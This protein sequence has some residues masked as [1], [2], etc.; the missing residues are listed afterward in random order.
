MKDLSFQLAPFLE[1]AGTHVADQL[2]SPRTL[3]LHTSFSLTPYHKQAKYIYVARE[4]KDTAVSNFYFARNGVGGPEYRS[5]TFDEFFDKYID[6]QVIYGDY[7]DHLMGWWEH[8][9]DDNVLFL[10]YE[11]MKKDPHASVLQVARFISNDSVDYEKL[12]TENNCLVLN[13]IVENTSFQCMKR[14]IEVVVQTATN[15]SSGDSRMDKGVAVT[16]FFRK[17]IVGDWMNHFSD[18]QVARLN[19]RF[20]EKAGNSGLVQL[21]Q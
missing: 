15:S 7:F 6:G 10:T 12:L 13:R 18:Q 3:H 9:N 14:D 8:V 19:Q 11:N 21:W 20:I 1:R 17:G 4:P 16:D 5:A 2:P